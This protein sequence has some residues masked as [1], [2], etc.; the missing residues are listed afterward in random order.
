MKRTLLVVLLACLCALS[1]CFQWTEDAQ[2]NLQSAGLPGLPIW[3]SKAPPAPMNPT[4]LGFTPEE[5]SKLGGEVLVMP[6][7]NAKGL[8]YRY[9]QIGQNHCQDDLKKMMADRSQQDATDPA[10]YCTDNPTQPP[11]KGS[12]LIF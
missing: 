12:A 3:Q 1:G 7:A 11:M 5:A 8:R 4:D 6:T 9:Y 2:G 10:P